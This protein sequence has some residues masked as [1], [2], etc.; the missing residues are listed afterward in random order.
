MIFSRED[1]SVDPLNNSEFPENM[2]SE[3]NIVPKEQMDF[4]PIWMKVVQE[5]STELS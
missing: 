2:Y 5:N 1:F 4:Y 3:R